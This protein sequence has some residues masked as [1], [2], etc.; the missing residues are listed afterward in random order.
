M[1][2]DRDD[3]A[4]DVP[5]RT[6]SPD[7]MRR[8]SQG[9]VQLALGDR[10]QA[11]ADGIRGDAGLPSEVRRGLLGSTAAPLI[12][13]GIDPGLRHC[14]VAIVR[15]Q[16]SALVAAWLSKNPLGP[17]DGD[18]ADVWQ[19]MADAVVSDLREELAKIG[20][21]IP[22][23]LAVERQFIA[24][25]FAKKK[26]RK[27]KTQNPGQILTLASVAG[28]LIGMI[29]A[30]EKVSPFPSQW[31]GSTKKKAVQSRIVRRLKFRHE[32]ELAPQA[33]LKSK[34]NNVTDAI[35]IALWAATHARCI[36][37]AQR[38]A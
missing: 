5:L 30:A 14:G 18:G 1:T 26:G 8:M 17:D 11:D 16:T 36:A 10:I 19:S 35:G 2:G 34:G 6:A 38:S 13:V 31:N 3:N 24:P 25:M 27:S 22:A 37:S 9:A 28:C 4:G 15:V 21:P 29:T 12:A 32:L 23:I 7:Q 20:G 33:E